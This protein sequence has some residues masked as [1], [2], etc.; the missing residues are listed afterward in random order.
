MNRVWHKVNLKRSL[1][2]LNSEFSFSLTS[3][4]TKAKELSQ[5]NY[6]PMIG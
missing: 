6:L 3:Y 5:P 4:Y 2:D 1:M